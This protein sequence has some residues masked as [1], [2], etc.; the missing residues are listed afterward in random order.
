MAPLGFGQ[1]TGIDVQGELRGVLPST[2]WKRKRFKKNEAQ[3]WYAGETISLGIGQGYNTFTMLQLAQAMATIATGGSA[4][5]RIWCDDIDDTPQRGAR[6]RRALA[7]H[8][9]SPSTS[10]SSTTRSAA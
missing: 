2:E 7:A 5:R 9:G 10:P 3:K 8:A 1:L 4:S 6:R